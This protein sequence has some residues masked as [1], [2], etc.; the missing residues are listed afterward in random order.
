MLRFNQVFTKIHGKTET[1]KSETIQK[2]FNDSYLLMETITEDYQDD[3]EDV[4]EQDD[5]IL[6]FLINFNNEQ[7]ILNG[8]KLDY[9]HLYK[10]YND[11]YN[12]DSKNLIDII[13]TLDKLMCNKVND[14][15]IILTQNK[16]LLTQELHPMLYDESNKLIITLRLFDSCIINGNFNLMKV[17]LSHKT[18][19]DNN[20]NS[21]N[22]IK[23][24]VQYGHLDILKF[25]LKYYDNIIINGGE[26]GELYILAAKYGYLEI[27]EIFKDVDDNYYKKALVHAIKGK[28]NNVSENDKE[29]FQNVIDHIFLNM[30]Y[31]FEMIE[32][33]H[34]NE[35]Y[36]DLY[37]SDDD[38]EI[39]VEEIFNLNRKL[40]FYTVGSDLEE[41]KR[42][43]PW[44]TN[45]FKKNILIYAIESDSVE[46]VNYALKFCSVSVKLL[47]YALERNNLLI[48]QILIDKVNF[49]YMNPSKSLLL[50]AKNGNLD[51]FKKISKYF[52]FNYNEIL[53]KAVNFNNVDIVKFIFDKEKFNYL[54]FHEILNNCVNLS[55]AL[56]YLK[57]FEFFYDHTF[58]NDLLVLENNNNNEY[59]YNIYDKTLILMKQLCSRNQV[60]MMKYVFSKNINKE[61]ILILF[62]YS[63]EFNSCESFKYLITLINEESELNLSLL[64]GILTGQIDIVKI[65]CEYVSKYFIKTTAYNYSTS[66]KNKEITNYLKNY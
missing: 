64:N 51:I 56:G 12:I 63:Y 39:D 60:K 35:Y 4:Y 55:G 58:K 25:L 30:A 7:I 26:Y 19:D 32:E 33:D 57:L 3:D 36:E 52:R 6:G 50:A 43:E 2:I 28:V 5:K 20:H 14:I 38:D 1:E 42:L 46:M 22:S 24:A 15:L 49:I 16:P 31:D 37:D 59:I 66:Y 65:A 8:T 44:F 11:D 48:I 45:I 27:I 23:L 17:I 61:I 62:K 13:F 29:R 40:H 21:L 34:Q 41:I 47:N 53:L 10:I 9:N 18:R 54:L